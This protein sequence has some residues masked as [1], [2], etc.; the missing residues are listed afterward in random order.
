MSSGPDRTRCTRPA[1]SWR[2]TWAS[3]ARSRRGSAHGTR[4][5]R[6]A[7]GAAGGNRWRAA[8]PVTLSVTR[9]SDELFLVTSDARAGPARRAVAQVVRLDAHDPPMLAALSTGTPVDVSR[10]VGIDGIDEVPLGWDCPA[11]GVPVPITSVTDT[12]T[13][14][15]FGQ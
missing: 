7:T 4:R 2:P 1:P 14:L 3:R 12:T 13:L 9:L 10:A 6:V 5:W 8:V 11:P 15:R